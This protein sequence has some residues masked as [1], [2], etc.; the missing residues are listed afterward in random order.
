MEDASSNKF[1]SFT[2]VRRNC[3]VV[4]IGNV[5]I[6]GNNPICVQSMLNIDTKDIGSNINEALSL[7]KLGCNIIRVAIPDKESLNLLEKLKENT[8]MPVVADIH[9]DYKLAVEAVAAGADKIRINPGNIG[10]KQNIKKIVV[11]CQKKNIP[12]RVGIN[13]GSLEKDILEKYGSPNSEALFESAL[14]SIEL[15]ESLDFYNLVLSVKSSDVMTSVKAYEMIANACEY[16]LHLGITETGNGNLAVVKSA[17]GIGTLLLNGI[18][19]TIRV[20]LTDTPQKE[21]L[22]ARDILYS[23]GLLKDYGPE[24]IACPTCGRTKIDIIKITKDVKKRLSGCKKNIKVA[25]M[26]CAVNGP[27]EAKEADIGIAGGDGC[28]IIFKKGEI[29]KKVDEGSI[30]ESLIKEIETI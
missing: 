29:L 15:F 17:V 2:K 10:S 16:P 11:T 27:G 8:N 25:I 7:Q 18:G 13:S 26:G 19:D 9:F 21:V 30:I 12:I 22:C 14:R 28:A 20:T 3:K 6:G 4:G 1:G 23:V 24:V 5:K